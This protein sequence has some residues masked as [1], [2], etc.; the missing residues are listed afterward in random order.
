MQILVDS[1]KCLPNNS[2]T[3]NLDT[4]EGLNLA[5]KVPGGVELCSLKDLC[6]DFLSINRNW[7]KV[8]RFPLL[9]HEDLRTI[10][11]YATPEILQ[12][13]EANNE[14]LLDE[15]DELWKPV[16]QKKFGSNINSNG[17]KWR[18][19]WVNLHQEQTAR[20]SQVSEKLKL[21]QAKE[22]EMK[23]KM[24]IQR[25]DTKQAMKLS[26]KKSRLKG[27]NGETSNTSVN[28]AL[29]DNVGKQRLSNLRKESS[30]IQQTLYRR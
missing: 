2:S 8:V 22:K 20:L 13:V 27:L 10:F 11:G 9:H 26:V 19:M 6:I 24:A 16:V 25:V 17:K 28:S 15:L 3:N 18:D 5:G 12:R 23:E 30:R 7:E 1:S 21:R 4:L 14:H 29:K